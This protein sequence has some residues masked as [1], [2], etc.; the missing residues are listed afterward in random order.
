MATWNNL[1]TLASYEKLAGLK[2]HVDIKEAMSRQRL[3]QTRVKQTLRTYWL[4][5]L[6]FNSMLQ[7]VVDD[8]APASRS[9]K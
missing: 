9:N 1:D 4:R 5:V 2:N 8:T 7:S 6:G 3:V